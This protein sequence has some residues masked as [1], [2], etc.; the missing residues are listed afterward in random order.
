MAAVRC[1]TTTTGYSP[2][3]TT[4]P[5]CTRTASSKQ[6][7]QTWQNA[8]QGGAS[9]QGVDANSAGAGGAKAGGD[10]GQADQ[11]GADGQPGSQG[12]PNISAAPP[13]SVGAKGSDMAAVDV[14][15][16]MVGGVVAP[17]GSLV[18]GVVNGRKKNKEEKRERDK[19]K[20][21]KG[22]QGRAFPVPL[23]KSGDNMKAGRE[24]CGAT[25]IKLVYLENLPIIRTAKPATFFPMWTKGFCPLLGMPADSKVGRSC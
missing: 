21:I 14:V 7:R 24:R 15:K 20:E 25:C 12:D 10:S 19:R 18:C 8:A 1:S 3:S 4:A 6:A 9:A 5:G 22:A 2:T 11:G 13:G 17:F 16:N 23:F